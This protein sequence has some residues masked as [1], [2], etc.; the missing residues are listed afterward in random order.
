M[1]NA[2][3]A[4]AVL[5]IGLLTSCAASPVAFDPGRA[6]DTARVTLAPGSYQQLSGWSADGVA[7]AVPAF[8]KSCARMEAQQP[9]DAPLDPSAKGADFGRLKDWRP[10]C[11]LAANL[12]AGDDAAARRFFEA[13]FV[14]TLIGSAGASKGLFTGYWEVEL[15]GSL[16]REGPYQ[17]P[18]YR[19]P[20]DLTDK[21]YLDRAA[22]EDGAL[23]GK[24][25][26]IVWLESPDDLFVLQMQGS[27]RIRLQDGGTM[28]LV[29]QANNNRPLVNVY[30]LLVA[31][32]AIPP[33][34][35]SEA[36]VRAW[37]RDNPAKA[38]EIRRK[39]PLYVFFQPLKGEGPVGYQ[40]AVLTP[41]RSLAVDHRYIPLGAPVWLEAH[42]KYRPVTL[43]R[44]VVAQDT[45]DGITGPLRA[46]YY[47]GSGK[48]A[49]AH[50]SD[51]YADGQY[52]VLLPK[53]VA[54]HMV[55]AAD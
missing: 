19:K 34:R 1:I 17:T 51:F 9:D 37:M 13:N 43:S 35:L 47:W 23:D 21:P 5:A 31:S 15:N 44:L 18:V 11:R 4:S 14:P 27:G 50:G 38:A 7:A 32:G 54:T 46:D 42:D 3:R 26:E 36:N 48:T 12:P 55:A 52:W 39:D 10:L 29:Y 28:R 20:A 45:G 16:T 49:A 25:L 2:H 41:E 53:S 24:G 30:Q 22:I 8:V 33:A 40:G 6:P